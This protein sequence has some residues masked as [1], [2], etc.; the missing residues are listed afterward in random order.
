M[1]D[2]LWSNKSVLVIDDSPLVREDLSHTYESAG[3]RVVAEAANGAAALGLY[4][5]HR[6]DLVSLDLI[7]PEMDGVE[8]F[9]RLKELD[10]ELKCL[11]VSWLGSE[12]QIIESLAS[13]LPVD[14]IL[15]KPLGLSELELRLKK[16]F[17]LEAPAVPEE[18]GS[19]PTKVAS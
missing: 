17:D 6:P 9:R 19:E 12:A 7:M 11:I 4:T 2:K 13:L 3:L 18:A 5:K 1:S 16:L 8:C 14:F 10:P 15:P